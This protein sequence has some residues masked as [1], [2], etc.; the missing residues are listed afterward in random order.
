MRALSLDFQAASPVSAMGWALLAAGLLVASLALWSGLRVSAEADMQRQRL[1]QV[2]QQLQQ[3]GLLAAP[4]SNTPDRNELARLNEVLQISAQMNRPWDALFAMLEGLQR[5][6][7]ALLGLSPD[8]RK[9]QLR[10]VAEARDLPS[11]LAFHSRLEQSDE[12]SDVSLLNHEV[13]TQQVERPIRFNL[14]ANWEVGD[15]RVSAARP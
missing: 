1:A 12:L 15:A 9:R 14:L 4:R 2:E 13:L 5:K 8:A 10:I 3:R 7:I 11:M 6:D